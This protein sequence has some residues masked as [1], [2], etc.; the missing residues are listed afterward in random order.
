REW[1][2]ENCRGHRP[3]RW[4]GR[5]LGSGQWLRDE[6]RLCAALA[7]PSISNDEENRHGHWHVPLPDD[8]RSAWRTNRGR[9]ARG[10]RHPVSS[11]A[12]LAQGFQ[13]KPSL[14]IV[15]DD[16]DI[17]TQLKW[18]LNDDYA[19]FLAGD[20]TSALEVVRNVRPSVVLLDLGLPP[21]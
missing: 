19:V 9:N 12:A 4:L 2:R 5:A 20:R 13:M 10:Q 21:H 1:D 18:A 17:R 3:A 8:Y 6:C 16:Q 14:L 15:D 11:N 7:L